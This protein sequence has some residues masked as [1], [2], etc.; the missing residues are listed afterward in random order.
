MGFAEANPAEQEQRIEAGTC[1]MLRDAAGASIGE[2]VRLPD[3][4]RLECESCVECR[5]DLGSRIVGPG[6]RLDFRIRRAPGGAYG[7][8]NGRVPN[9]ARNGLEA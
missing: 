4:E 7:R 8:R 3:D 2:L 1:R 6:R 9:R 5:R